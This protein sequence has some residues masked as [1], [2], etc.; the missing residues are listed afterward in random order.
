MTKELRR[1]AACAD[2]YSYIP[3]FTFDI[4]PF[5]PTRG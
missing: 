3:V 4:W 5:N 2:A 1:G